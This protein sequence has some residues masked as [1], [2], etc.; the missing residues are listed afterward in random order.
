[1][2]EVRKQVSQQFEQPLEILSN[3]I[4]VMNESI[5]KSQKAAEDNAELLQNLL[6]G[7][8]NMGENF[9]KLREDMELWQSPEYQDV[10]REYEQMNR[11]L[12]EE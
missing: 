5:K 10:E 9:E 11:E 3:R 7:I 2:G 6:V 8:E 12:M 1:M 4:D